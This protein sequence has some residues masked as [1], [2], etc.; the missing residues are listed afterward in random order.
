MKRILFCIFILF[1]IAVPVKAESVEIPEPSGEAQKYMPEE[2]QNFGEGLLYV[3]SK[4][5]VSLAPALK[6]ATVIC[7]GILSI[8]LMSAI[9]RNFTDEAK[10]VVDLGATVILG[11]L[12]LSPANALIQLGIS[13]V[14]ELSEYGKLFMPAMATALAAQGGIGS[15]AALYAATIAFTTILTTAVSNLIV[16]LIYIYLCVSIASAAVNEEMLKKIK[17]FIKWLISWSL[18]IL[19]YVYL[20]YISITG[21]ISGTADATAV[22]AVKL[23]ISAAV[24][25]VGGILSD[26]S[27]TILVG[28]ASVK[29]AA[30]IYGVFAMLS[31]WIGPFLK[32][33]AQFVVLKLTGA[34]CGVF[35]SDRV[36]DLTKDFSTAMGLVLA[37]TGTQCLLLIVSTVCF[38]RGV[39]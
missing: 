23:S 35:G 28:A 13:V 24:P 14:K 15:S 19:L 27:E 38:M 1:I 18:K 33:A 7:S 37:M 36:I 16:P 30:G 2:P 12:L 5:L 10:S 17:A 22:K 21:V 3:F 9:L 20:A 4:A 11:L 8:S 29:N 31:I 34:I 32:I 6:N 26:A 39:T 25:V